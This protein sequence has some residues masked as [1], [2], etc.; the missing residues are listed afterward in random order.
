MGT[1][2]SRRTT[3]AVAGVVVAVIVVLNAFLIQQLV[4]PTV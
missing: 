1:L 3:T 2:A 4:A